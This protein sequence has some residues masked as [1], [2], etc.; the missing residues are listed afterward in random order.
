MTTTAYYYGITDK[1][2]NPGTICKRKCKMLDQ[3]K[4]DK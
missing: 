1:T 3:N 2:V 4:I